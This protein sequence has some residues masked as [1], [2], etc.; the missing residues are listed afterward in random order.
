MNRVGKLICYI[1]VL[2]LSIYF[3]WLSDNIRYQA[4]KYSLYTK[5]GDMK[6]TMRLEYGKYA[7]FGT[8]EVLMVYLIIYRIY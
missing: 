1:D 8:D 4:M 5:F 2:K 6:Y 7:E 3:I